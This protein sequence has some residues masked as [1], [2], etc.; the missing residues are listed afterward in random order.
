MSFRQRGSPPRDRGDRTRVNMTSTGSG[1]RRFRRSG[2]RS[3]LRG[4]RLNARPDH[5]TE[6]ASACLRRRYSVRFIS[7]RWLEVRSA[8]GPVRMSAVTS[9]SSPFAEAARLN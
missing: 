6:A 2:R 5:F 9:M 4:V 7:T 3:L 8:C 1:F